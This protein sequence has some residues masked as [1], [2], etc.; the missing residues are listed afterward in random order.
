MSPGVAVRQASGAGHV[1]R[2]RAVSR[3]PGA[4]DAAGEEGES[5]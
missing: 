3:I 5:A 1:V 2:H 4:R